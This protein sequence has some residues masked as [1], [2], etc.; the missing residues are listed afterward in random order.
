MNNGCYECQK[1]TSGNC[2]Q[3]YGAGMT[4]ADAREEARHEAERLLAQIT[5]ATESVFTA[6][7]FDDLKAKM[8]AASPGLST[9]ADVL[10]ERM[11]AASVSEEHGKPLSARWQELFWALPSGEMRSKLRALE[12]DVSRLLREH[13]PSS[14]WQSITSA[15]KDLDSPSSVRVDEIRQ[16]IDK[17]RQRWEL[18]TQDP[19]D[20]S[21][22]ELV[23][24][25]EDLDRLI[26]A[27]LAQVHAMNTRP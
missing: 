16:E 17:A 23:A 27:L 25:G 22:G 24:A 21:E 14:R 26:A 3:H 18:A 20:R 12:I 11:R 4:P 5:S 10:R 1:A 6:E 19:Y 8:D 15:P 7:T 9:V 13:D 2:G